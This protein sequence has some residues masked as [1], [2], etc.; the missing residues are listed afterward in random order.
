MSRDLQLDA[1]RGIAA[2]LV[3]IHHYL[4]A[5]Y[6]YTVF[7]GG[8]GY[9]Q[10]AEWEEWFFY[11][12]IGTLNAGH[13]AV[14]LFFILSGYVLSYGYV[15]EAAKPSKLLSAAVRR[16][17][18]LGGVVAATICLGYLVSSVSWDFNHAASLLTGSRPWLNDF[19]G[20]DISLQ[21]FLKDFFGS[22]FSSSYKYNP[23]LWTIK[24]ELYGSLAVYGFL[25]FFSGYK[26]RTAL[27]IILILFLHASLYQ[28]FFIGILMA[29]VKKNTNIMEVLSQKKYLKYAII[30][31]LI[32]LIAYPQNV[33][34]EFLQNTIYS[35]LPSKQIFNPATLSAFLCFSLVILSSK[36]QL[37][38]GNSKMQFLGSVSYALY[39]IHFIVL[40][41]FSS[42]LFLMI[43]PTLGYS[44]GFLMTLVSGVFVSCLA[45]ILVT[46]FI[47][48]PAIKLANSCG[49]KF[50]VD[51]SKIRF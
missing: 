24:I 6:P 34:E 8:V 17:I 38:L 46:Q 22:L 23:P 33:S 27:I 44:L 1:L 25:L 12:L 14:C 10:K 15:G 16:P 21:E 11:P 7:G 40:G 43:A 41:S 2:L 51:I 9:V 47:D 5:F 32:Y 28:G 39:A 36:L 20:A 37:L 18:R 4:C 50:D 3:V 45:A 26:Y 48:N 19:W 13:F 29:D 42:W 31:A 30:I 49:K 35:H